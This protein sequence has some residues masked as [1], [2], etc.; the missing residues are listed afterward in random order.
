[1]DLD[2]ALLD[3]VDIRRGASKI[4]AASLPLISSPSRSCVPLRE[5]E[6]SLLE[7]PPSTF[8]HHPHSISDSPSQ[9]SDAILLEVSP[10]S[11]PLISRPQEGASPTPLFSEAHFPPLVS[12]R[13]SPLGSP[14]LS[15]VASPSFVD[16]SLQKYLSIFSD[17]TPLSPSVLPLD[18]IRFEN[19]TI[20]RKK[21]SI[22]PH[23]DSVDI[24]SASYTPLSM[25]LK[26]AARINSSPFQR[27]LRASTPQRT[28]T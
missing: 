5:S 12:S 7:P 1:M 22:K 24:V 23:L 8:D 17:K 15:P 25:R 6:V 28:I 4:S 20:R 13:P 3:S 21:K 14:P 2:L 11:S 18:S 19:V 27:V 10:Y 9:D 16:P 26:A